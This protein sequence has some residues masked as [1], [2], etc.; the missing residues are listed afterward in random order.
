MWEALFSRD[1]VKGALSDF[2]RLGKVT[3]H[4]YRTRVG[5]NWRELRFRKDKPRCSRYLVA[6]STCKIYLSI[7]LAFSPLLQCD[8]NTIPHSLILFFFL[9]FTLAFY[10]R[11]SASSSGVLLRF[12]GIR[13]LREEENVNFNNANE[14]YG[15]VKGTR[16]HADRLMWCDRD[17]CWPITLPFRV[18]SV[19]LNE[20]HQQ[21][22]GKKTSIHRNACE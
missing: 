7:R 18:A 3:N 9:L 14:I 2:Q 10:C 6:S 11:D 19:G 20:T 21:Q 12:A 17:D 13:N 5:T 1:T 22:K 16:R 8:R 15:V 4:D